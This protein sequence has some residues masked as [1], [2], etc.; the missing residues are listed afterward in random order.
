MPT[1]D[2]N[3]EHFKGVMEQVEARLSNGDADR[4][5]ASIEPPVVNRVETLHKAEELDPQTLRLTVTI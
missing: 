2:K 1:N 4:A 3:A 5:F